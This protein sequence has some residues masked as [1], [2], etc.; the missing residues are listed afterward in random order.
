MDIIYGDIELHVGQ[1][2]LVSLSI[3]WAIVTIIRGIM[4]VEQ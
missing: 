4:E 1:L 2:T 3:I